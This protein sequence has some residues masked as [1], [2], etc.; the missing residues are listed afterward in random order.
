MS[1][2]CCVDCQ[3]LANGHCVFQSFYGGNGSIVSG[4]DALAER[5]IRSVARAFAAE[6]YDF[7]RCHENCG[8]K[9][10]T[11]WPG[12]M[13][14]KVDPKLFCKT[15]PKLKDYLA[16]HKHGRKVERLGNVYWEDTGEITEGV[17]AELFFYDMAR[18]AIV[19]MLG[20]PGT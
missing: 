5:T 8:E 17:P 20:R 12:G 6:Y 1:L 19:Q 3:F 13:T 4:S 7:V 2:E 14:Q 15:Y 9:L 18:Q 11:R 10:H 16:G